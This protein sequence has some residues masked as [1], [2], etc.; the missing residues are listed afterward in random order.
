MIHEA[1]SYIRVELRDRLPVSDAEVMIESARVLATQNNNQGAYIT[2]VNVEEEPTL[3]NLPSVE[4]LGG[5][6]IR[7]EPPVH[8]NLYLLFSFEFQTYEN[9]LRHL[10]NTIGLFQEKRVY[11]AENASPGNPFPA[12]LEKLVFEIHNMNFEALNNLWGVMGGAYFPS[13]V[14]KVRM[15]RIQ[16]AQQ[17]PAGGITTVVLNTALKTAGADA[18]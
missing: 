13:V 12:G 7:R 6:L 10:S 5:A 1:L 17:A 11:T 9:S 16:T 18:S 3:R 4:R 8:L 15:V 14:Y 2:L